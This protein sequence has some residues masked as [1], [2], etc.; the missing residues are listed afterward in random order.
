MEEEE[1]ME[2]K[3]GRKLGRVRRRATPQYYFA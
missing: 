3:K 1:E 2:G